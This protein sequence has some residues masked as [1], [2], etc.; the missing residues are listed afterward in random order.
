MATH[1]IASTLPPKKSVDFTKYRIVKPGWI[2][3]SVA[4]GKLLPWSDY[5]VLDEGPRQKVLKFDSSKGITQESPKAKHGYRDQ[6]EDSFYTGQFK[7]SNGSTQPWSQVVERTDSPALPP[8]QTPHRGQ[9]R[10]SAQEADTSAMET[11]SKANNIAFQNSNEQ[12]SGSKHPSLPPEGAEPSEDKSAVADN[13]RAAEPPKEATSEEHNAWLLSDPRLRKSSTANPEFL[14]QYYSES[15]LHHLS[16]WKAELKSKMQRMAA[17]KGATGKPPKRKPGA[18]RYIMHVDFDSFFCAISLKKH[19]EYIDKPAVVAHGNGS[20]SEIASCNYPAREFGVKNGMWMKRALELCSDLKVLPYDFPAYE[21]A[22]QL[23]YESIL[24]VGGTVQSVS[25]DEAL[26][27]VSSVVLDAAGSQGVG[28]D[29]G[30]IWREQEKVDEIARNLRERIKE[31]TGCHVSVGI[32]GNILQAKVALRKAKPAGQFQLKPDEVLDFIGELKVENLPGVAYSIGGKLEDVGV[33]LVKDLRELSKARLSSVLGPKTGEKLHEY[34]RGIDRTEV[35]EQTPRKSVSAEVNWGIRF[36]SQEEAEEFVYNLCKELEK[37]LLNEQV[38]GRQMTLKVMRRSLDAPLDP[39]KHLGHGK[40]DVFNKSMAFGVATSSNEA[41][42]REAVNILR[43]FKFSPGDLRGLGVQMTKLEPI[44][45]NPGAPESSQRKLT[46]N[47]FAKPSPGRKSSETEP[48]DD[49]NSPQKRQGKMDSD[50][51]A[52]DPLTPRKQKVHPAMALSKA[53]MSDPKSRTPLNVAGTQFLIPSNVDPAT[54]A[55]LP[56]DIR[57]KLMAQSKPRAE[58]RSESPGPKSRSE[59]PLPDVVPTQVDADVFNALPD[60]MKAEVLAQY[61]RKPTHHSPRKE[62]ALHAKQKTTP[63]KRG[64]IKNIFG[65]AQRQRDAQAGLMQTNFRS[66]IN[67]EPP[68]EEVV[69]ELDPEFLA[70]LPEDVRKEVVAD[71]RRQRLAMRSGLDAPSRRQQ[72]GDAE[73][74]ESDQRTIQFAPV[75]PKITFAK[76]GV[77]SA[78]EIKDMLDAW[79]LDT[80]DEGPH[81]RDVVVLE[82]YLTRVIGEERDMEKAV[83][84]VRWLDLVVVQDGRPGKGQDAWYKTVSGIKDVVQTAVKKRGLGPLDL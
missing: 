21:D 75:P 58:A 33:K 61:G 6:I 67:S 15:R 27:D 25:I 63:T 72:H 34:A 62:Q 40:C 74:F 43:S 47:T 56:N 2:M 5:R 71:H 54:L 16:T 18:R 64:G 26:V 48:I 42:G 66:R 39:A 38:K 69:G 70:Q 30:S 81:R 60:D 53:A 52:D 50:P 14:K 31:K 46:F 23:F 83:K 82:K 11:P 77:T 76:S 28:V 73:A 57:S 13:P 45:L 68:P 3:D 84:I 79:H 80:R 78:Q 10:S 17:D 24:E 7:K 51:I 20:G 9:E 22:S 41:I 8:F 32:G 35:G 12:A 4:A 37:R 19:P 55:E 36:I 59:S 1:I 49:G 29:E 65:K 44:K